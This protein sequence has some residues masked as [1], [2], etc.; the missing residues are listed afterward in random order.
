MLILSGRN[1]LTIQESNNGELDYWHCWRANSLLTCLQICTVLLIEIQFELKK[2]KMNQNFAQKFCRRGQT[3]VTQ[4][5]EEDLTEPKNSWEEFMGSN[6]S[7]RSL[8][9]S[10]FF[11]PKKS[12]QSYCQCQ[13]CAS[14]SSKA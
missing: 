9:G 8:T 7:G 13:S 5:I 11:D 14:P 6:I 1:K 4:N 10:H 2:N 12:A 3:V